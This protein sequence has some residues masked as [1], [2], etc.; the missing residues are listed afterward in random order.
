MKKQYLHII[1]ITIVFVI[2]LFFSFNSF[3]QTMTVIRGPYLQSG[4]S[5]STIVKWRTSNSTNSQVWYGTDVNS[6]N[7]TEVVSG[8]RTDHEVTVSGL[9]PNTIYY[10]AIG[11]S[12]AQMVG[13]NGD[14]SYYFKTAPTIGSSQPVTAWILGDCGTRSIN[15]SLRNA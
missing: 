6:L 11:D 15:D 3:S 5:T 7:Q 10:Y 2:G 8:I 13:G 4:I 9:V 14:A 12:L 1:K